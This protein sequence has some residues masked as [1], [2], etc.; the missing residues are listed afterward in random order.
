MQMEMDQPKVHMNHMEKK[1][2][3]G[4]NKFGNKHQSKIFKVQ[5]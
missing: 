1:V 4:K 5:T 3:K 2:L